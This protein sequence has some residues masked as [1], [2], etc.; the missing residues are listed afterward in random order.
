ML[1]NAIIAFFAALGIFFLIQGIKHWFYRP[2]PKGE[3]MLISTVISLSG[4]APELEASVKALN[5]LRECGVLPGEIVIQNCGTDE[6]TARV[7]QLLAG[8]DGVKIIT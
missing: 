3:N 7:A 6:E 2:V 4:P 8:K 5:C 1:T